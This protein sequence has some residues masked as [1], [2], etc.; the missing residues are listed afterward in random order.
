MANKPLSQI[1]PGTCHLI[2]QA[3]RVPPANYRTIVNQPGAVRRIA[4]RAAAE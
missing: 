2:G 3:L 1:R 4:S